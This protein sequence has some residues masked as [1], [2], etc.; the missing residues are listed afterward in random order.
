MIDEVKLARAY[1]RALKLEKSGKHQAAAALYRECLALDP[2]DHGGA[3]VR[4]AAMNEGPTPTKASDAY[5][6][7]LFHQQAE[8]FEAILVD[9]LGY[10]VPELLGE[11]LAGLGLDR[12]GRVLDLGCGT[13]LSGEVLRER[14][15]HLT[16]VDLAEGMIEV[17]HEK[18][19]Y[20]QLYV[21]EV[22]NFLEQADERWDLVVAT[23]VLPYLGD[24]D[25]FFA[26]AARCLTSHG[27]LGVSSER[28]EA[29]ASQA[30]FI[31]GP[32]QRFAH[33]ERYLRDHLTSHGFDVLSL[34]EIT[35][36]HEMGE[37]VPGHLVIARRSV[38]A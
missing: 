14:A 19:I 3:A 22:V 38:V 34:E 16:G 6:A 2:Q 31:V 23:D 27:L 33:Q 25:G 12:F 37:P 35:V 29:D 10:D 9:Q 17:A 26:G 5:V 11:R 21:G 1:N 24:L 20:D 32:H 13:G 4:L 8:M 15:E 36:R 30:P 7:T 28:I 18:E